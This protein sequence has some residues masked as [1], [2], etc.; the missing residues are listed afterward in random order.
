MENQQQESQPIPRPHPG[1]AEGGQNQPAAPSAV[2]GL[3]RNARKP[4]KKLIIFAGIA[5]LG[6]L[7]NI[8]FGTYDWYL[9]ERGCSMQ[10]SVLCS[11]GTQLT[12][13]SGRWRCMN[14]NIEDFNGCTMEA[15]LC[16]DGSS[17]GRTGP[18]CEFASCPSEASCEGGACPSATTD[19][20]ANWQ[21]YRNEEY[22][23]EVKYPSDWKFEQLYSNSNNSGVK[24][25]FISS[26]ES[27]LAILPQGEWD[28]GAFCSVSDDV[29]SGKSVRVQTC[30][31]STGFLTLYH[32]INSVPSSWITC[33][34]ELKSCN[35][36]D[37]FAVTKDDLDILN[38]ILSTFKFIK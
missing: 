7:V 17:V 16:P 30:E 12:C 31:R 27:R 26:N 29:L 21:T 4:D 2:G 1:S 35:R 3:Q 11:D 18:N 5:V 9:D 25:Y 28:Y 37:S 34:D 15:K 22:G 10:P 33:S 23:F 38:Q 14:I 8:G 19:A 6:W 32:F 20:T 36:I 13:F 24:G